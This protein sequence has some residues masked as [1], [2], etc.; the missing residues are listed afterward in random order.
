MTKKAIEKPAPIKPATTTTT[1]PKYYRK[2]DIF[3]YCYYLILFFLAPLVLIRIYV[4]NDNLEPDWA[5]FYGQII[6]YTGMFTAVLT[7]ILIGLAFTTK[8]N[9]MYTL[10]HHELFKASEKEKF[11]TYKQVSFQM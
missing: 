3:F 5:Q 6:Y 9:V 8:Y 1:R 7:F 10:L 2:L 4:Y 11:G